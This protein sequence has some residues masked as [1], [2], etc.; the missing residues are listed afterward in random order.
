MKRSLL[1]RAASTLH[2]R[3][4]V[5]D[6]F[7]FFVSLMKFVFCSSFFSHSSLGI[8]T[9][10]W[11]FVCSH[12]SPLS[13]PCAHLNSIFSNFWKRNNKINKIKEKNEKISSFLNALSGLANTLH[14]SGG[15]KVLV[16]VRPQ[17]GWLLEK[18]GRART[19]NDASHVIIVIILIMIIDCR[20]S[21]KQVGMLRY[22]YDTHTQESGPTMAATPSSTIPNNSTT[23]Q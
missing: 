13:R 11:A 16:C 1:P 20:Y 10:V 12:C 22:K 9:F 19:Q 23:Q 17:M 14:C 21:K 8:L 18:N 15:W 2:T 5:F 7:S 4:N 3:C 6:V